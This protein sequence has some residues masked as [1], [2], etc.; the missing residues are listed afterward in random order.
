[1]RAPTLGLRMTGQRVLELRM[2]KTI[3]VSSLCVMLAGVASTLQAQAGIGSDAVV[4]P[5]TVTACEAQVISDVAAAR[6][7]L[8]TTLQK[9]QPAA[10]SFAERIQGDGYM[11][12]FTEAGRVDVAT[13]AYLFRG[14]ATA[15]TLLVNGTP[16]IVDVND[17]A[18]YKAIDV[19]KHP[20]YAAIAKSGDVDLWAD[21]PAPPRAESLPGGGQ[22]FRFELELKK[23]HACEPAGVATVAF[24]FSAAGKFLGVRLLDLRGKSRVRGAS[25]RRALVRAQ[26]RPGW[27][28]RVPQT[29]RACGRRAAL[30][31]LCR[32]ARAGR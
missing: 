1:M 25:L 11:S 7:C 8:I 24:D 20:R 16:A 2:S 14:N 27:R 19:K 21:D 17:P 29:T 28:P 26:R 4:A 32:A 31:A 15:G 22:R 13:V 3:R 9:S 5:G 10:A 30:R 6:K 12:G 23:C 18:T